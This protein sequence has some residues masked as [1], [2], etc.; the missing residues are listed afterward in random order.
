MR[1]TK[2]K[3][4]SLIV[5]SISK[6]HLIISLRGLS[7]VTGPRR[8]PKWPRLKADPSNIQGCTINNT[9]TTGAFFIMIEIFTQ[10]PSFCI[11][12]TSETRMTN[13][14]EMWLFI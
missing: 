8:W 6:I 2:M 9:T 3:D 5:K 13:Y 1:L 4:V 7:L 11:L 10:N 14:N 12:V